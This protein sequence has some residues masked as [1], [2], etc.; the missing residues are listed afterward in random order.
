MRYN[1]KS[2][3]GGCSPRYTRGHEYYVAYCTCSKKGYDVRNGPNSERVICAKTDRQSYQIPN[4]PH[5]LSKE[6]CKAFQDAY[7]CS[8]FNTNDDGWCTD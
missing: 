5:F 8:K 3:S 4:Q 7:D 2:Q 6:E 1:C